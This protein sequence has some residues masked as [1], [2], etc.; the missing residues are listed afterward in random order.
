M[1]YL[2]EL[3]GLNLPKDMFAVFGSGPLAIRKL[4]DNE[5]IDLIVEKELWN[6]LKKKYK[7]K[8]KNLI[9]VR[10]I[11]IYKD[12]LPWFKNINKL[13]D[14]ADIIYGLRFVKLKYVLKW[15]KVMNREKNRRDIKLIEGLL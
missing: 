10:Y 5:D 8:N 11:M 14:N 2:S 9:Q 1:K 6:N 4:R 3:K 13:I 15:K 7:L 12:W